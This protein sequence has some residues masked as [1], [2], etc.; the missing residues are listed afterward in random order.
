MRN[1]ILSALISFSF[2]TLSQSASASEKKDIKK[3]RLVTLVR[4]IKSQSP[5]PK[6]QAAAETL[7]ER[8]LRRSSF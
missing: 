4:E 8:N 5:S 3:F 1:L 2:Y 6:K 7:Q